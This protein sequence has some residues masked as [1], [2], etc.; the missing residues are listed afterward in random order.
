VLA[1]AVVQ[2]MRATGIPNGIAGV[3]YGTGDIA[4]LVD[5]T[6]PQQRLLSN[7]PCELPRPTLTALFES[8]LRY[9]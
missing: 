6:V 5:G 1:D 2:L 8:A 3:G 9:W 4:G 7:A